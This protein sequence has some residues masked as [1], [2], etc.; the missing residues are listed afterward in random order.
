MPRALIF[1]ASGQ[2]GVPL[3]AR[4]CA[5]GWSLDAVSRQPRA[6]GPALAWHTGTLRAPPAGLPRR[7]DAVFSCGPLD[8]FA[9]WYADHGVDTAHVVAVGSTSA[10]VKHDSTDPAERDVAT[11][12]RVAEAQVFTTAAARGAQATVLRPTLVYGAGRDATLTRIAALARRSGVFPLPRGACGLRQ[13][14]HVEDLADAA[15]A[16]LSAPGAAGRTYDLPGGETVAYRDMVAR[17]LACLQP[18]ARLL[19]L[20]APLFSLA[21]RLAAMAGT[22][23]S[24][25]DAAVARMRDDLVFDAGPAI[26]DLGYAPRP[27]QPVADM[28]V[29]RE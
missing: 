23:A 1:G 9:R 12:L 5:A 4:L 16:C 26:R 28:F 8:G 3:V 17:V 15:L 25:G 24:L 21:L 11:R 10:A 19:E 22:G 2:I 13:P 27:F 20:P 29:A 18:P 7:V 6:D 14:V